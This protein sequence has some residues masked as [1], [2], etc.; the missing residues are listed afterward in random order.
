MD[1]E[2][3]CEARVSVPQAIAE[4]ERHGFFGDFDDTSVFDATTGEDVASIDSDGTVSGR[5]VL[6]W[7]GY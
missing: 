1:F 7:L 3:A 4:M 6:F 2:A 5:D